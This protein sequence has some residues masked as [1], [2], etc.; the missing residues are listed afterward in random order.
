MRFIDSSRTS[1]RTFRSD[2]GGASLTVVID[3]SNPVSDVRLLLVG[4]SVR[5]QV[6]M[7]LVL[8]PTEVVAIANGIDGACARGYR[9]VKNFNLVQE[10]G[11]DSFRVQSDTRGEPFRHGVTFEYIDSRTRFG[12][13]AYVFLDDDNGREFA[14]FLRSAVEA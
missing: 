13:S 7:E 12:D 11:P 10:D 1:R 4:E 2:E 3:R 14:K 8:D 5:D 6:S 9:D